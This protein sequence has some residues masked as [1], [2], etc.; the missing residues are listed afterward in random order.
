MKISIVGNSAAGK[1][2]LARSLSQSVGINLFIVD[3]IY[4]LSGW[5]QEAH[6]VFAK[7]HREWLDNNS[8][9]IDGLGYWPEIE[10]RIN[11]SDFVI[12][13]DVPMSVC[14][15]RAQ[16]RTHEEAV[17][18]N[19][20]VPNSCFYSDVIDLQMSVIENFDLEIRAK[21]VPLLNTKAPGKVIVIGDINE[22]DSRLLAKLKT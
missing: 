12:F 5:Q 16:L 8:W 18:P 15:E 10:Q 1:S 3:N 13:L 17:S 2:T 9:I 4:W 20:N 19:T 6:H 21:L 22:L 11:E 7:V 14:K